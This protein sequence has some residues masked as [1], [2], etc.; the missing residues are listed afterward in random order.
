[1]AASFEGQVVLILNGK[2]ITFIKSIKEAENRNRERVL[3]ITLTGDHAGWV[4]GPREVDLD[5]EAYRPKT[6]DVDWGAIAG[7]TV[8][9]LSR[10]GVIR[11]TVYTD[12]V[13]MSVDRSFEEKGAATVSVKAFG[14]KVVAT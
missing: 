2:P 11:A 1:M 8:A 5:I 7:A 10:E 3:G 13:V 9:T 14:R 6:G 4:D 12:V